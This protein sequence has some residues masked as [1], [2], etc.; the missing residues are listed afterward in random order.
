FITIILTTKGGQENEWIQK[1]FTK[2]PG[3]ALAAYRTQGC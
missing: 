1:Q 2:R 3:L